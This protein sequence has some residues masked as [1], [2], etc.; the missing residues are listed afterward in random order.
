MVTPLT[1]KEHLSQELISS[2]VVLLDFYADWCGPCRMIAPLMEELQ[3]DNA[4]RGVKVLKVNID[5]HPDLA[6]EFWVT[7]IPIV[8]FAQKGEIKEGLLGA[9]PKEKYQEKIDSY[10]I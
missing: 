9:Y 6:E 2:P 7:T 1:S 3:Q 8:F 5:E 4:G 10:L